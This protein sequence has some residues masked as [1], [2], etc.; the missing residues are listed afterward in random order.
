MAIIYENK[1]ISLTEESA[2]RFVDKLKSKN[3][4]ASKKRDI[5]LKQAKSELKVTNVNNITVITTK[6]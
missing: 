1:K 6:R 2:K 5:F 4:E 3:L